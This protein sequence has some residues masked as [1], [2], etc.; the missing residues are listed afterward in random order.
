M[1]RLKRLCAFYG[2]NPQFI[3]S[4]ATIHNPA[5]LAGNIIGEPVTLIDNNGAPNGEKHFLMYNPPVI[6]FD[7]GLRR[8]VVNEV[9]Q[10]VRKLL[11][12]GAQMIIFARSRMRVE[13]LTT[14]L[15]D[16]AREQKIDPDKIK[17]YRGGYLPKERRK[18]ERGL[19]DGSIRVVVSTNALE[20]GIDI[21]QLDVAIMAGY[22]GSVASAWQQAGRAG[23][24][25]SVALTIMVASSA[26]LDQYIVE[27]PDYFFGKN[28]EN[29]FVDRENLPILM[30]HLKCAA[31]ELPF[32]EDEEFVP[33]LTRPLLDFLADERILRKTGGQY[34]WM[35]DIYPADEVSLR[36][37]TQENVVI[38][39]TGNQ[40]RV[41]GEIDLFAAQEMVHD[42]AIY[43]HGSVPYYVD[44]LNWDELKAYVHRLDSDHY[45]D[46]ITKVDVKVLDILKEKNTGG[47]SKSFADV[48]VARTTTGYKKIKFRT[49]E[50]IGFGRVYLPEL[51]MQT[52]A[53]ILRFADDFFEN[54]GLKESAIGEGLNGIAYCMQNLAPL[55]VMCDRTDI[56]V[57]AMVRDPFSGGPAL[58]LYDKYQG[59]IGLC[60]KLYHIDET[61][62]RATLEHIR[63]CSCPHGCPSCVGPSLEVSELAKV[64]AVTILERALIN[65]RKE[66]L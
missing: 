29:A 61:L 4:S 60:K 64:H 32:K 36:N 39:D 47:Y 56:A 17:G 3:C 30:S 23:R 27:N 51:E 66:S 63:A 31:F 54:A 24:R 57:F 41:I 38:I 26:P 16:L 65:T 45:T 59:G 37:A 15:H 46:A 43:L 22:P 2:S 52:N 5:E 21:G 11:P 44:K 40:N 33:A 20:L 49:H 62:V 1:A 53:L 8:G 19:K 28:P 7:L 12:T 9:K 6:N 13:L 14:Y 55:Y 42:E 35:Q 18:I 48:A 34:F 25:Q 58:Y 10:I 50:N